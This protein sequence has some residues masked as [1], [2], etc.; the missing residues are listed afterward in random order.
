MILINLFVIFILFYESVYATHQFFTIGLP[1]LL[2]DKPELSRDFLINF[3]KYQNVKIWGIKENYTYIV[4]FETNS[5]IKQRLLSDTIINEHR[6]MKIVNS[7]NKRDLVIV[8]CI[9]HVTLELLQLPNQFETT[10]EDFYHGINNV[11]ILRFVNQKQINSIVNTLNRNPSVLGMEFRKKHVKSN[12]HALTTGIFGEDTLSYQSSLPNEFGKGSIVTISDT[13]IDLSHCYFSHPDHVVHKYKL[14]NRNAKSVVESILTGDP[15]LHPKIIAYFSL[16]FKDNNKFFFT[17]FYDDKNGHGTHVAGSVAPGS[18]HPDCIEGSKKASLRYST[19][20]TPLSKARILFFDLQQSLDKDINDTLLTPTSLMWIMETSYK[21]GSR[22]F[23]NSWGDPD[24]CSYSFMAAQIDMFIHLNQDYSVLFAAGNSGPGR[25]TIGSPATFKN[26]ITIGATLN[27]Y[28]SYEEYIKKNE[29]WFNESRAITENDMKSSKAFYNEDQLADFSSRGPTQDGRIKPDVVFPG[30]YILS[31]RSRGGLNKRIPHND[32]LL[33]RGTSMATPLVASLMT[34]IEERLKHT[35]NYPSASL[36]KNILITSTTKLKGSS[37]IIEHTYTPNNTTK[38]DEFDQGFGR[39]NLNA[40]LQGKLTFKDRLEIFAYQKPIIFCFKKI[41]SIEDTL[42]LVYDDVPNMFPGEN[43]KIL[44]NDLNLRI[45]IIRNEQIINILNGNN[46][47][48]SLDNLNNVEQIRFKAEIG[49]EIRVNVGSRGPLVTLRPDMIQSQ[50]FS[51]VWTDG[52]KETT[53][54]CANTC[55]EWDLS[56][57]CIDQSS[58]LYAITGIK[59][60]KN[61]IYESECSIE[62]YQTFQLCDEG[63]YQN[64][65]NSMCS[66]CLNFNYPI[67]TTLRKRRELQDSIKYISKDAKKR[68]RISIPFLLWFGGLATLIGIFTCIHVYTHKSNS[69]INLRRY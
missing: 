62:N 19:S 36:K 27:S 59:Q 8:T 40:F 3:Q 52:I 24:G 28:L 58:T 15:S 67:T 31:S 37:Q 42:T 55:N 2:W 1:P 6:P 63:K 30:E 18:I 48:K 23:T 66:T 57:E 49:D 69:N 5:K 22:I 68:V 54:S 50:F 46:K 26:G 41:L 43:K 39:V 60:C 45:V 25:C 14:N 33:F 32:M 21:L 17:D 64:C 38:I 47:I 56:Y 65:I 61:G 7:A 35:V 13:G 34:I 16:E 10:T 4:S 9:D 51:L 11:L 53:G 20:K 12:H 29:W 44:I